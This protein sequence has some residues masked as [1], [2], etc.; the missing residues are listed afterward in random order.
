MSTATWHVGDA[1]GV[2][3]TL[4]AGTADMVFTSPPY[5]Q[6][7]SYVPDDDPAKAHEIG[8]EDTPGAF[9]D[10]LLDVV[11]EL[12]RVLT[13]DGTL[14]LVLGD[15][16]AGSGG[17][18]G[19][20]NPG[21]LR[22]GQARYTG[23]AAARR[24]RPDAIPAR[25]R[26]SA[27]P[28]D[29]S[30]CWVPQLVAASMA[31]GRNLLTG[32]HHTQW[33]TRPPVTWCK[34]NPTVGRLT[35]TFRTATELVIYA[36]KHQAHHFDLDAVRR[37]PKDDRRRRGTSD[38]AGHPRVRR[39]GREANPRGV[40]PLNWWTVRTSRYRGAHFATFPPALVRIPVLAG[41]PEGG[42]VLDPFAGSGTTLEVALAYRRHAVGIDLDPRCLDLA[43]HRLGLLGHDLQLATNTA[44]GAA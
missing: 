18:G 10:R 31:Y 25:R 4:P 42:V 38:Y 30:V 15:T 9:I 33:V 28:K 32:Q 39:T 40:P 16:H 44:E 7:R 35:R 43:R 24:R 27:W 29:Q 19:D 11:D 1:L 41:C 22:A 8:Q 21:G 6:L 20:Y 26:S 23:S 13:D 36:G 12:H 3:R 5:L 34:P 17:A 37:P 2:L 14:W